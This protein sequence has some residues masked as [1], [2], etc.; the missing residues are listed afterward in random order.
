MSHAFLSNTALAVSW[1]ITVSVLQQ[2]G[3]KRSL[4]LGK[5]STWISGE[6]LLTTID[7]LSH[8]YRKIICLVRFFAAPII[9][10]D[11][12]FKAMIYLYVFGLEAG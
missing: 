2:G 8:L 11:F 10:G 4:S 7:N 12:S 1:W 9:Q 6:G 3:L 5:V